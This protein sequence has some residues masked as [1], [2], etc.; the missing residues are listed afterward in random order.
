MT[1]V[2]LSNTNNVDDDILNKWCLYTIEMTLKSRSA[3]IINCYDDDIINKCMQ[4]INLTVKEC[5]DLLLLMH[6]KI[7]RNFLLNWIAQLSEYLAI[8][9]IL[10]FNNVALTDVVADMFWTMKTTERIQ[11]VVDVMI[12]MWHWD[13]VNVSE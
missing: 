12:M 10:I 6:C 5:R 2:M 13:N 7:I 8:V 3:D 9:V 1:A 11:L 4:I